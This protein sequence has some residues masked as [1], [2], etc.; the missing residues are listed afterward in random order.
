MATKA[1]A[2]AAEVARI[3]SNI[4]ADLDIIRRVAKTTPNDVNL[5]S[6]RALAVSLRATANWASAELT[7]DRREMKAARN[8]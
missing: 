7:I 5:G 2:R 8:G 6:I 3:R 4:N 1:E